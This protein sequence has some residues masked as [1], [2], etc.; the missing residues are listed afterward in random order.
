MACF[1]A[2]WRVVVVVAS[3]AV[4]VAAFHC[5]R[6]AVCRFHFEFGF[7]I[8]A[9][10]IAVCSLFLLSLLCAI[11]NL[12]KITIGSAFFANVVFFHSYVFNYFSPFYFSFF[13]AAN[14][15]RHFFSPNRA[16]LLV[17]VGNFSPVAAAAPLFSING[18]FLVLLYL[19]SAASTFY[20][21]VLTL[22]MSVKM[23]TIELVDS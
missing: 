1:D 13:V 6:P 16:T 12:L 21:L 14:L 7:C 23:F 9:L 10:A 4:V 3:A 8:C 11:C 2:C 5:H 15:L 20:R 17:V 22:I 18:L 19:T